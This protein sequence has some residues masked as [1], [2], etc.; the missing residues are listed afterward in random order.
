MKVKSSLKSA[1]NR[2]KDSQIVSR[3]GKL[4]VIDKKNPR[5]KT[6]QG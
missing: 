1:K 3:R 2:S 4:Y 5:Y 6:R